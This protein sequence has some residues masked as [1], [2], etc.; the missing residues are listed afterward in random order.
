MVAPK[1]RITSELL[2]IALVITLLRGNPRLLPQDPRLL[3]TNFFNDV[4]PDRVLVEGQ[5]WAFSRSSYHHL[6]DS[7]FQPVK[8]LG[9]TLDFDPLDPD[10]DEFVL[11][12][13][14]E[15]FYRQQSNL[16][17][18]SSLNAVNQR[19]DVIPTFNDITAYLVSDTTADPSRLAPFIP[20]PITVS[21]G[22]GA[23][24]PPTTTRTESESDSGSDS[25]DESV[26]RGE[27]DLLLTVTVTQDPDLLHHEQVEEEKD[28]YETDVVMGEEEETQVVPNA[29]IQPPPASSSLT[30]LEL[31]EDITVGDVVRKN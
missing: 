30:S 4:Y 2:H 5:N 21:S 26:A 13:D 12:L 25:G 24:T 1:K 8:S 28:G 23:V 17:T 29:A 14:I 20:P 22:G 11:D 3:S 19:K 18:L 6:I 9:P 16:L 10:P 31:N 27:N 7:G 15:E